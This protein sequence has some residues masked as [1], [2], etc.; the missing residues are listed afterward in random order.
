MK[1]L[2]IGG[3]GIIS[4][5]VVRKLLEDSSN[6]IH[7]I[8]R[9]MHKFP[10]ELEQKKN[11]RHII[12]DINEVKDIGEIYD[13]NSEQ[14]KGGGGGWLFDCVINFV[15]FEESQIVRDY[16]LF[17]KHVKQYIYISSAAVYQK[18]VENFLVTESQ[19]KRNPYWMYAQKKLAAEKKATDLYQEYGF[20]V[21]IIRPHSTYSEAS[22]LVAFRGAKGSNGTWTVLKRMIEKKPVIVPGDGNSLWTL[23][24]AKDVANGIVGLIG[25]SKAIGHDFHI[26]SDESVTWNQIYDFIADALGV[27]CFKYHISTDLLV[28]FNQIDYGAGTN[29]LIGDACYSMKFDNTKIKR[30]VPDYQCKIRCET[31]IHESVQHILQCPELQIYDQEFDIWCDRAIQ[32]A[33]KSK[34]YFKELYGKAE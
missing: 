1:V 27:E 4:S 24:H 28:A 30:F 33:E 5:Y 12:C 7:C 19:P 17:A 6:E 26:T 29:S 8:T 25:N 20:P 9:G 15:V 10:D 31:G 13:I 11:F 2:I 18:P 32:A 21:T 34:D 3:S 23:S 22:C 16:K 14:R